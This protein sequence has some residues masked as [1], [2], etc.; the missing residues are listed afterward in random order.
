MKSYAA[1]IIALM[2]NV[3]F[4][5]QL[6]AQDKVVVVVR[7]DNPV[8]KMTRSQVIDLFMGKYVAFP[9]GKKAIAADL[10]GKQETK[11]I[12]YQQLVGRSLASINA[13]WSRI[14]FIGRKKAPRQQASETAMIAF[15]E[16][17]ESA[18]GY[19]PMSLMNKNLKV[20]YE[21]DE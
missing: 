20:V 15:I 5:V 18:I 13:Y 11:A 12:F 8:D 6:L 10:D 3:L 19:I 7:A 17:N 2:V 1:I 16:N 4:S 21:L 14:R 9:D